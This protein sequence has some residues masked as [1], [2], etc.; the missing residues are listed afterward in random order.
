[1]DLTCWFPGAAEWFGVDVTVRYPGATRYYGAAD[2]AGRAATKAEAEKIK[3]YGQDIMPIAYE[4]GGRLGPQSRDA[5]RKLAQHAASAGGGG[6]LTAAGLENKW[7]RDLETALFFAV[8]DTLILAMGSDEATQLAKQGPGPPGP[9]GLAETQLPRRQPCPAAKPDA[10]ADEAQ[11]PLDLEDCFLEVFGGDPS[12]WALGHTEQD[13][14]RDEEEIAAQ[15]HG[16]SRS[17]EAAGSQAAT[18]HNEEACFQ[19]GEGH[20]ALFHFPHE[21]CVVELCDETTT[22]PPGHAAPGGS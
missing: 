17:L 22:T 9:P 21:H 7:R 16:D 11:P 4:T 10:V 3:R 13:E 14:F 5:L 8:A 6:L 15:L 18:A 2:H 12:E 20:Q 19:H 1:M